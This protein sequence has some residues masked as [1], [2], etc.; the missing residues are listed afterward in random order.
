MD[1]APAGGGFAAVF[2]SPTLVWLLRSCLA[3]PDADFYQRELADL[4]A[5][6]AKT[7]GIA[8]VLRA[9][10]LPLRSRIDL[11]FVFGSAAGRELAASDVDLLIVSGH[12]PRLLAT[13]LAEAG[14]QLGREVNVTAYSTD[15]F[16]AKVAAGRP[17]LTGVLD[18][19]KIW[20]VG[21]DA[22]LRAV[23]D[24]VEALSA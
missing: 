16:R 20:L 14:Q 1:A 17:L 7:G 22:E 5:V 15:E 2:A 6:F 12:D 18:G 23:L 21:S 24:G 10:L 19:A 13:V 9:P 8:D 11:E 4:Q 3:R